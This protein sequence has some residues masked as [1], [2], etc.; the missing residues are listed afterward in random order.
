MTSLSRIGRKFLL[1]RIS[2]FRI[3]CFYDIC[4]YQA[5]YWKITGLKK[6]SRHIFKETIIPHIP[7]T[8]YFVL[9]SLALMSNVREGLREWR[10]LT[11][12]VGC[13]R[14]LNTVFSICCKRLCKT[15]F[16]TIV[17]NHNGP[18]IRDIYYCPYCGLNLTCFQATVIAAFLKGAVD[19]FECRDDQ[20]VVN[21]KG[22]FR[23]LAEKWGGGIFQDTP[24]VPVVT[25]IRGN[26]CTRNVV[27][28]VQRNPAGCT[29]GVAVGSEAWG[30]GKRIRDLEKDRDIQKEEI[31]QLE[32]GIEVQ[33]SVIKGI[34]SKCNKL[35]VDINQLEQKI[36]TTQYAHAY[37][38]SKLGKRHARSPEDILKEGVRENGCFSLFSENLG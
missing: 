37:E 30:G 21:K 31:R 15:C 4:A 13:K 17:N 25:N 32:K 8:F 28:S 22:L 35:L 33:N 27:T 12:C 29:Y 14:R 9:T 19:K 6:N 34:A 36:V 10:G 1:S 7:L 11:C 23:L 20:V 38:V 16:F 18:L 3:I 26:E 5:F 2:G 24:A